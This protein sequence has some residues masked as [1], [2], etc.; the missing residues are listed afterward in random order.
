MNTFIN[1][2]RMDEIACRHGCGLHPRLR[3]AIEA[4]LAWPTKAASPESEV[5]EGE[6]PENVVRFEP[7]DEREKEQAV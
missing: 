3:V 1:L 7:R 4:D 5:V 2:L 6:L